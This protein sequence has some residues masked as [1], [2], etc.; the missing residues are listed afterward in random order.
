MHVFLSDLDGTLIDIRDRLAYA[1]LEA[2]Q[3]FG[4]QIDL[5]RLRALSL[6]MLRTKQL[7][8]ALNINL[9]PVEFG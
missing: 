1:H 3:R 6:A 8:T 9:S 4:Y 5:S 2:L 7:L